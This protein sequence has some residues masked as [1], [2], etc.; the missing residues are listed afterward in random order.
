MDRPKYVSLGMSGPMEE[1]P[2]KAIYFRAI[3]W[4]IHLKRALKRAL[5]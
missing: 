4:Y 3:L 1:L 2:Y 5:T